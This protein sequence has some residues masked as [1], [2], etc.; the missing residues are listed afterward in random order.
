[1]P[2]HLVTL[3]Y[4]HGEKHGSTETFYR[5]A[6]DGRRASD[7]GGPDGL[8]PFLNL[9]PA[10]TVLQAIRAQEE[11]GLRRVYLRLCWIHGRKNT[12]AP[13]NPGIAAKIQFPVSGGGHRG[14]ELRGLID[15]HVARDALGNDAP[16][17]GFLSDLA[18]LGRRI[19]ELSLCARSLR[20]QHPKNEVL[21]YGLD[22]D[23]PGATLVE[24]RNPEFVPAVGSYV[25]FGGGGLRWLLRSRGYVVLASRPRFLSVYHEW[26][27]VR[28]IDVGAERLLGDGPVWC[29]QLEYDYDR[30]GEL[31]FTGFGTY[32]TGP[33]YFPCS[34]AVESPWRSPL[35][36]CGRIVDFLRHTY[37]TRMAF[38]RE[39]PGQTVRVRWYRP[40]I[41]P[42]AALGQPQTVEEIPAVPWEHPFA[43]RQW[44][45][46]GDFLPALGE[47]LAYT[48]NNGRPKALL[49]GIGLCGSR[50]AW[51]NGAKIDEPLRPINV[52][53]GQP[54]CCGAGALVLEGG[55]GPGP[56][57]QAII[58]Q[59]GGAGGGRLELVTTPEVI[60]TCGHCPDGAYRR[61]RIVIAGATGLQAQW[62]G[63][64]VVE[65]DG[66][67]V[68][69]DWTAAGPTED[70]FIT[71]NIF[72]FPPLHVQ[73]GADDFTTASG[74]FYEVNLED[75]DC[76]ATPF[77]LDLGTSD[78]VGMPL[79]LAVYPE[80]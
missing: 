68:G 40:E 13:D 59:G 28:D 42:G 24:L 8:A 29:R 72:N 66:G 31:E 36:P 57:P 69:C 14:Y 10:S 80:F 38:W 43:S 22:E 44:E 79:T 23:N 37:T 77:V 32:P 50:D 51:E 16:G 39:D 6:E 1:M 9:R 3:I 20:R 47:L 54:C 25:D 60:S 4:R 18:Q 67:V 61:Y 73:V 19:G 17:P 71:F 74:F 34:W 62:N 35:S 5:D 58:V 45:R 70:S 48:R 26:G 2:P 64:W 56:A 41:I 55:A 65:F 15:S 76:L 49:R 75:E 33:A 7:F 30:L 63:E 21:R 27:D 12:P 11:S 46:A 78:P 52:T 53:T